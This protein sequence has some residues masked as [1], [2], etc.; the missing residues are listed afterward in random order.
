[1]NGIKLDII[2]NKI[3]INKTFAKKM[4]NT[5]SQEYREYEKVVSLNPGF[6]VQVK[7]QK[8]YDRE[9][10]KG[11]TYKFIEAYIY[12]HELDASK[13]QKVFSEYVEER[14]KA[15]AHKCNYQE[16]RAWFIK[17]YPEFDNMYF[18]S[19]TEPTRSK[20]EELMINTACIENGKFIFSESQELLTA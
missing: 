12:C 18:E 14:W 19:H 1:M 20:I 16:V 4:A 9:N 17:K 6:E 7:T 15:L 8:T 3:I 10:Y 13:R 5:N 11:L 2:N